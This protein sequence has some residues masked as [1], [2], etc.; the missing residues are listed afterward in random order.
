MVSQEEILIY[1]D[2]RIRPISLV[3]LREHFGV[4]KSNLAKKIKKMNEYGIIEI[5]IKNRR[6]W[7]R[8]N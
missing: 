2:G 8:K 3:K 6:Y 5:T 1:L 4:D 7:I